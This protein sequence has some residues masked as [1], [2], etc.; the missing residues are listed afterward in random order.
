MIKLINV[1]K[2]FRGQT[3]LDGIDLH[4]RRGE[5]TVLIGRS[6]SGK[7]VTLKHIIGLIPPDSGQV[8]IDDEDITR[9]NSVELNKLRRK[10][11]MLFQDGALF[12]SMTVAENVGFPLKESRKYTRKEIEDKVRE[13][14]DEVG[15]HGI[16]HKL[17]SELSGGMRKRVALARAIVLS[18]LIML[19]D[20]PTTG[21]DPLMTDSINRL[22]VN[23]QEHLQHTVFIIS[24]DI[25]ASLRIADQIAVL[26]DGKIIAAGPPDEIRASKD[27]FIQAFISGE[28]GEEFDED[29]G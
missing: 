20:E 13:S 5:I 24:H 17:P 25:D 11:G 7:S 26:R 19:Y 21:L 27:P 29:V 18:P 3:I 14:L 1:R 22:I 4:C 12:D 28:H 6:G 2:A 8:M 16:E 10:F 15:L 9:L 23:T